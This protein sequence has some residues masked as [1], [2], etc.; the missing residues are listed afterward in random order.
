MDIEPCHK[1]R[2]RFGSLS[3]ECSVFGSIPIST[4]ATDVGKLLVITIKQTTGNIYSPGF[5][6]GPCATFS[7]NFVKIGLVVFV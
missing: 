6:R 4:A 2:V 1:V 7:L 5:F 3:H